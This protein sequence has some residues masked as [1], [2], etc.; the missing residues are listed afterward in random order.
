MSTRTIATNTLQE[1]TMSHE[2]DQYTLWQILGIWASA[3]LPMGLI[4]WVVT[5]FLIPRLPV[6]PG[7]VYLLSIVLGLVW[8]GV[9]A[10]IILRREVKPFT[11]ANIKD[12]V[13]LHTP[14]DPKTG[15]RSGWL[16][17]WTIPLIAFAQ[18]AQANLGFLEDLMAKAIPFLSPP[19]WTVIQN[20]AEPAVGQWWLL[21]VLA[22]MIAFNYLVG[23]ELI[24][25][26]ILLP[27]MN[28]VF[29]K[30]DFIANH[31]LFVTYHLHKIASWPGFLPVD[32]IFPWAAKRFK[33]YWVAVI[34]HGSEAV[35]L[36]ILF[37]MAIMGL[38]Q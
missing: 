29:G 11:W 2:H 14:A 21:G 34:L 33:S 3:A 37:P 23:E 9:V 27:R 35:I 1:L 24:F 15:V 31:I 30:W 16:F 26:G 28:G 12:R 17:L 13:W 38:L 8:Q 18:I 7:F 36:V 6:N 19:P 10:Y 20:M 4:R 22:V 25:R 5:P 32:W